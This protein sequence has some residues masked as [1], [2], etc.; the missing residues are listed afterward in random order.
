[1]L[2]IFNRVCKNCHVSCEVGYCSV[3]ENSS[4]C[5]KCNS[6]LYMKLTS[7][8]CVNANS[9]DTDYFGLIFFFYY[10]I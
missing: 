5:T 6:S 10:L 4:T 7:N 8:L 2:N 3:G 9:C 1:M